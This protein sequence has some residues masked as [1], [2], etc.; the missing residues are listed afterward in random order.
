MLWPLSRLVL[1]PL[2]VLCA[3]PHHAPLFQGELLPLSFT[4]ILGLTNGLFGSL[5]IILA[6]ST[7]KETEREL[8][9]NLMIFSYCCGL[10]MGSLTSYWLDSLLDYQALPCLPD[11]NKPSHIHRS[12]TNVIQI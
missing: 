10:T 4:V 12:V 2:L 9:G 3:A 8:A 6:P 1:L 11:Y 7:V 5:P